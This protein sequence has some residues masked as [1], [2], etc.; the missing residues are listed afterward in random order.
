MEQMVDNVSS[1]VDIAKR[2]VM[3][4]DVEVVQK[5]T[6]ELCSALQQ[7]RDKL[8]Y[9]D[10]MAEKVNRLKSIVIELLKTSH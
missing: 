3:G 5:K 2:A 7:T 4:L 8:L 9:V 6:L 1:H 10:V